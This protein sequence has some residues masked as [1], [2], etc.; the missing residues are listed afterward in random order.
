MGAFSYPAHV[1]EKALATIAAGQIHPAMYFNL[2]VGLDRIG[3]GFQA[4]AEGR[5]LKVLVKP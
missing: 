4:A 5:A 3:E 1:H 2:I